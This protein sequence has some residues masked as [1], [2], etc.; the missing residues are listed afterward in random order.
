MI[1]A[2]LDII[3]N[4]VIN[5]IHVLGYPGVFLLMLGE[6]CGLPI[7]SEAIMPFAGFQVVQGT[8]NFWIIVILGTLGNIGGSL[9]AFYIG[10]KG[11]IPLIKKYGKYV[12]I[13]HHDVETAHRWFQ[14]RGELM[15]FLGRFLPV[16]RTYISFPAGFAEMDVK[17]FTIYTTLGTIPW[18]LLFAWL[19][20][21]MGNNWEIIR[22]KLHNFD[23][24]IAGLIILAVGLYVYRHLRQK[25]KHREAEARARAQEQNQQ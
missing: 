1:S 20:V 3:V 4:F 19:G 8:M 21:K 14:K 18:V 24:L 10:K 2:I 15:V 16:I 9:I 25:K 12:L 22:E 11:G 5:T 17:K 7:P 6:S 13:S 23:L